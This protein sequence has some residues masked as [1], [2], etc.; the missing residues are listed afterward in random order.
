MLLHQATIVKEICLDGY[1]TIPRKT[2]NK[3]LSIL[4]DGYYPIFTME[5]VAEVLP[6][7][8]QPGQ[9]YPSRAVEWP[10]LTVEDEIEA[11]IMEILQII[12]AGG[13]LDE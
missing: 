2:E 5:A 1:S 13:V 9:A 10:G 11:E 4:T 6:I 12:I 3:L 8:G 7:G